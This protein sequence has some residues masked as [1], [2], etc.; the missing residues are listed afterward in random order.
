MNKRLW[1]DSYDDGVAPS[2]NYNGTT[3]IEYLN[4][5]VQDYPEH[6]VLNFMNCNMKYREFGDAV[7]RLATALANLG[8]KKGTRV[9]VQLPNIPQTPISFFAIQRLGAH[10]VMTNPLYMPREIKHQWNDSNCE[11]AIVADFIYDQKVR[12]LRG[13]VPVKQYIIASIP[14]YLKFPLRQLAPLKLKKMDP[15]SVAKV[16]PEAGV[17]FFRKLV[18]STAPAAPAVDIDI[19]DIA[20]IQYTGGTTGVSKGAVLTQRNIAYNA[21]MV[22]AW[23]VNVPYG[24]EVLLSA[25]P[26]FHIFGLTVCMIWPVSVAGKMILMPNPRD[27][28]TMVKNIEKH[29][30]TLYPALPALFNAVNQFPGIEKR[31]L[32]SV[33]YCFSGSAPLPEDVQETFE[34]LTGAIIVEGFGMTETSPVV[35]GNPLYGE[36]KIGH[37]GIPFPDT[38][39]KVVDPKDASIERAVGEEGELIVK[40]PQVMQ[41]YWNMPD[42]TALTIKNGW[43]HT[44]DL[45]I[46]DQGGYLRIVGRCKDMIIAGG[47]NIYPDEIDRVLTAHPKVFEACTIGVPDECRGETVKSFIILNPGEECTDAELDTYARA[48]LAAYKAP[49]SYEFREELPKSAMMKLL[50]RVLRDEEEAKMRKNN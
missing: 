48:E 44:G 14:E 31:D 10:A 1:H 41:G 24:E 34:K 23:F 42:E 36:R 46:M 33:K 29:K 4:K 12:A 15:P 37:I 40:G 47:Y 2:L 5:S 30:V 28:P 43:L 49:K 45:V 25:L 35:T 6:D 26:F 27:I 20:V 21:Q 11:I 3:L 8:V 50:R 16:A 39:V 9:A 13:D 18:E 22:N 19:D 7:E 17:H 32:S 38:D